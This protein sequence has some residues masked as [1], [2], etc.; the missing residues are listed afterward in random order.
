MTEGTGNQLQELD[1]V[2]RCLEGCEDSM[3]ALKGG[4]SA[5][6]DSVLRVSGA[7]P[8]ESEEILA[9]LWRDCLVSRPGKP[10]LLAKYNGISAL[11]QWL[12]AIVVNRWISLKRA[13]A[14]RER[15]HEKAAADDC[16]YRDSIL[17]DPEL[18]D[19]LERAVRD[20]VALCTAEE[21]VIFRLIYLYDLTQKEVASVFGM[22]ESTLSR[23]L[24][25]AEAMLSREI[26][27]RV[28]QADPHLDVC[29]EDFLRLCD[30]MALLRSVT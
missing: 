2:E 8:G 6:L 21:V 24:K 19:I 12:A 15:A 16:L 29:W 18:S 9:S 25:R 3:V 30:A 4:N 7:S 28:R 14:A 26:L 27:R 20:A 5:Y 13:Q 17:P 22:T 1:L 10:P 11:R 23:N